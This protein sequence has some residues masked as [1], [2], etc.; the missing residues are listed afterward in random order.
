MPNQ[1]AD[2]DIVGMVADDGVVP[3]LHAR[4]PARLGAG[5]DLVTVWLL[6]PVART[7][8]QDIRARLEQL[9]RARSPH[10]PDWLESGTGEWSGRQVF[11]LSGND[12]AQSVLAGQA[13][14][15]MSL[16]DRLRAVAGA[17]RGAHALH[18]QGVLH[19]AICPQAVLLVQEGRAVLAPSAV[20]DG[21]R[22]VLQIGY[23]PL[24][25]VDPQLVR[26]QS[27]RWSD[28][29]SLGA[30][31][32][33]VASG[34][35]PY[36]GIEELPVVQALTNLMQAPVPAPADIP[37]PVSELVDQCL[38]GDPSARP[39][40]ASEVADRLEQAAQAC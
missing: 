33:Y 6:G 23:P 11:W 34:T 32:R 9:A 4:P 17:A 40:T 26:G 21:K 16:A 5:A 24:G 20:A 38:A 10:L 35:V 12:R 13:L 36:P 7:S 18:E 22:P 27:G 14:Q 8:W 28:I 25:Y 19:G 3:C 1:I 2:Y 31:T 29:W 39:Q 15:T 37:G 30:V